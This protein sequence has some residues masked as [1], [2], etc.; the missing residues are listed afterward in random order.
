MSNSSNES[1]WQIS[2]S[3]NQIIKRLTKVNKFELIT[4]SNKSNHKQ[5]TTAVKLCQF[6]PP[7]RL[8]KQ[9][10]LTN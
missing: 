1:G 7:Q 8:L 4:T 3:Q 5:H 9:Y 6:T 10:K 2:T